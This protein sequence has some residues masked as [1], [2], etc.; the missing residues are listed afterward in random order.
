M[1]GR[2]AIP[3]FNFDPGTYIAVL[4]IQEGKNY[5][6]RQVVAKSVVEVNGKLAWE[7]VDFRYEF[8]TE[9]ADRGKRSISFP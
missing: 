8:E 2:I 4:P 9:V 6:Y 7:I 1:R 5:L 3:D